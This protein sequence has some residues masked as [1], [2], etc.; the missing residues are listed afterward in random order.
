MIVVFQVNCFLTLIY[1]T[2]HSFVTRLVSY[3]PPLEAPGKNEIS[4][5]H[6]SSMSELVSVA[7]RWVLDTRRFW[8]QI[9]RL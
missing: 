8:V 7:L 2:C 5:H 4:Q 1:K 6:V 9:S 3:R